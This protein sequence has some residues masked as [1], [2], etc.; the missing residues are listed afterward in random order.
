MRSKAYAGRRSAWFGLAPKE[1]RR[2]N[3]RGPEE[4]MP[5]THVHEGD[6]LSVRRGGKAPLVANM[7]QNLT[8]AFVYNYGV[9]CDETELGVGRGQ[10]ASLGQFGPGYGEVECDGA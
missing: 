6:H 4:D 1:A 8:F 3:A 9:A 7:R 2:V 10:C 5:L